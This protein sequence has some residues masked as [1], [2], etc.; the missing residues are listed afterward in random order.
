MKPK[1]LFLCTGNSARSQ[2]AEGYLRSV[3]GE[4]F[5]AMSA[6]IEPKGLNPLAVAAMREIGVDISSQR[7]KDVTEFLGTPVQYV[8]TVCSNAREKCPV[9]PATV[10]FMHWDLD[11]PA[12]AQ[13]TKDEKLAAFRKVR[14]EIFARVEQEFGARQGRD[15][16][17]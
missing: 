3:A 13:G 2:M 4:R 15:P 5:D 14:D 16:H 10:K 1:V 12:A 6:G 7:S 11:D 17:A 9:F 8:V